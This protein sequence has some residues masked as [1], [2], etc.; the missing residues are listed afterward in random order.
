MPW[1]R[2]GFVARACVNHSVCRVYTLRYTGA[3]LRRCISPGLQPEQPL[4]QRR[5][6]SWLSRVVLPRIARHA[7]RPAQRSAPSRDAFLSR[8]VVV[9]VCRLRYR[10][11]HGFVREEHRLPGRVRSVACVSVGQKAV[12]C[13]HAHK[14]TQERE[15][16]THTA[17][18]SDTGTF[19]AEAYSLNWFRARTYHEVSR[20]ARQCHHGH[21]EL[22]S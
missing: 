17:E 13:M 11:I 2:P 21:A 19:A 4:S 10:E 18:I 6:A 7:N 9:T 1:V 20:L 12:R 22:L 8:E 15:G 5:Q 16:E 14:Q 3:P